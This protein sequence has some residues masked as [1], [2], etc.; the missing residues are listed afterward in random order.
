MCVG[1]LDAQ[2]DLIGEIEW[3]DFSSLAKGLVA[4]VTE[5]GQNFL[6]GRSLGRSRRTAFPWQPGENPDLRW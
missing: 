5:M 4:A 6:S 3:C 1:C 2:G